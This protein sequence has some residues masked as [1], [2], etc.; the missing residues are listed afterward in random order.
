[1][2]L[3]Y[4]VNIKNPKKLLIWQHPQQTADMF[5]RTLWWLDLTFNS[6]QTDCLKT[7]YTDWLTNILKFVRRR[8]ESTVERCSV[9]RCCIMAIF[10]LWLSLYCL[11]SFYAIL[12]VLYT[13]LSKINSAIFL[14]QVAYDL[15]VN[16]DKHINC[17]VQRE[18]SVTFEFSNFTR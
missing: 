15:T 7:A 5:L 2:L 4:L 3:H 1:M 13:Y 14:W 8:L 18:N 9:E 11:R 6:S 10:S 12:H 17:H 16:F